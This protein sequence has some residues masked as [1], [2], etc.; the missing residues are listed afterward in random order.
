[1]TPT[2]VIQAALLLFTALTV[3]SAQ[4]ET[5]YRCGP[6][7]RLYSQTPCAQGRVVDVRDE[8]STEQLERGRALAD[9]QRAFGDGLEHDRLQREA[10]LSPAAAHIGNGATVAKPAPASAKAA[11]KKKRRGQKAT[12][13]ESSFTAMAPER[14]KH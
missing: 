8:R 3:A 14:R 2:T 6:D 5:I 7:G 1:M 12:Q 4:A 11:A 13:Q 9:A 10:R